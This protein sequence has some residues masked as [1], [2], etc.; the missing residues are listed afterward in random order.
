MH[1]YHEDFD[2][3]KVVLDP[4]LSPNVGVASQEPFIPLVPSVHH[5]LLKLNILYLAEVFI[6]C[7]TCL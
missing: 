1:Y 3:W 4:I 5:I 6:W 7:L 2:I